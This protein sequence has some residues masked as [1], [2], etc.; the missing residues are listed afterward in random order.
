MHV[1]IIIGSQIFLLSTRD[2]HNLQT[3]FWCGH[4]LTVIHSLVMWTVNDKQ[5]VIDRLDSLKGGNNAC[6]LIIHK[7]LLHFI[8]WGK[9]DSHSTT[10]KNSLCTQATAYFTDLYVILTQRG[11]RYAQNIMSNTVTARA[12][13]ITPHWPI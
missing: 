10:T 9:T 12:K 6:N 8:F 13:D 4:V 7:K 2:T 3:L 11:D 1:K 5:R